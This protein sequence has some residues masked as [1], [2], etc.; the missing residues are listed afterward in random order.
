MTEL[1]ETVQE[2]AA[3]VSAEIPD[4]VMQKNL[5]W[6]SGVS[7]DDFDNAVT[8]QR[9]W[10]EAVAILNTTPGNWLKLQRQCTSALLSMKKICLDIS[11]SVAGGEGKAA[12]R[13]RTQISIYADRVKNMREELRRLE[14]AHKDAEETLAR[15]VAAHDKSARADISIAETKAQIALDNLMA[16]LTKPIDARGEGRLPDNRA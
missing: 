16:E 5:G 1:T 10:D 9:V 8:I 6:V 15:I 2:Y 3:R 14:K 4:D 12:S 7:A 11:L 13:A